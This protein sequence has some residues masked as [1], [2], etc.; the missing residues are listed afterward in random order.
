MS[1]QALDAPPPPRRCKALQRMFSASFSADSTRRLATRRAHLDG[2][3]RGQ[4]VVTSPPSL[5]A[6][7]QPT[8]LHFPLTAFLVAFFLFFVAAGQ[9]QRTRLFCKEIP[10]EG[11]L[12]K[13]PDLLTQLPLLA[14]ELGSPAVA[15]K[16][17]GIKTNDTCHWWVITGFLKPCLLLCRAE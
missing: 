5:W 12:R 3:F 1:S 6:E 2:R 16:H 4:T 7:P 13:V 10:P 15:H 17:A 8:L 9:G 11:F 14:T